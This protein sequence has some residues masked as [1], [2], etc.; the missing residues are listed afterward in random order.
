VYKANFLNLILSWDFEARRFV[1]MKIVKSAEDFTEAALD[2]IE[3]SNE[4][5]IKSEKTFK[6]L[7]CVCDADPA[8]SSLQARDL[9]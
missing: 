4:F 9:Y 3:V 5:S 7:E 1:A 8:D 6:L 2:E